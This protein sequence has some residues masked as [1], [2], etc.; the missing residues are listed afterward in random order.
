MRLRFGPAG[1]SWLTG[2]LLASIAGCT[3]S[4]QPWT[5]PT[6]PPPPGA[7]PVIDG[8]SP[9]PPGLLPGSAMRPPLPNGGADS[10][11]QV[12]K[13]LNEADDQRKAYQEQVLTLRKQLKDREDTLRNASYEM[14]ES[15]K[16]IKRTRD[17]FRVW[18]GE[19][20][21]LRD[22]I[23]KLEDNRDSLRPLIEGILRQLDRDREPPKMTSPGTPGT[24]SI[25]RQDKRN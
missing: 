24:V 16:Q 14:E 2:L 7:A 10:M 11:V 9:Y 3:I 20:D 17:D 22:R 8:Q 19:I 6:P 25:E 15:S 5:K 12:I 21:E 1:A 4:I 18:Q 13:Q 23:R